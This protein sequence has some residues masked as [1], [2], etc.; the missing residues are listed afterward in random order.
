[1]HKTLHWKILRHTHTTLLLLLLVQYINYCTSSSLTEML[2]NTVVGGIYYIVLYTH[3]Q[4]KIEIK[5]T[6]L[7]LLFIYYNNNDIIYYYCCYTNTDSLDEY[8]IST[9]IG[10]FVVVHQY[11]FSCTLHIIALYYMCVCVHC[12][13]I[14]APAAY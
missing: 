2:V 10:S 11:R 13:A 4:R 14:S 8:M 12:V 3:T 5:Q 9:S 7:I 6:H 1:M